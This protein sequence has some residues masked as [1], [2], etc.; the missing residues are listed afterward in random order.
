MSLTFQLLLSLIINNIL[1]L[2][3]ITLNQTDQ[4]QNP[5]PYTKKTHKKRKTKKQKNHQSIPIITSFSRIIPNLI[6]LNPTFRNIQH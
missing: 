3:N 1:K 6:T 2:I 5:S 4:N